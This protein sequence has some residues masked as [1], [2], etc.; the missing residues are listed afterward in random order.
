MSRMSRRSEASQRELGTIAE[1]FVEHC[2]SVLV[3]LRLLA[4]RWPDAFT[5]GVSPRCCM[6]SIMHS[7]SVQWSQISVVQLLRAAGSREF[8]SLLVRTGELELSI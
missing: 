7:Y 1:L 6:C 2:V 3:I 5:L 4:S 8:A